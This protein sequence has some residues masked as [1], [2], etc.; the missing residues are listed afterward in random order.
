MVVQVDQMSRTAQYILVRLG[1]ALF[2]KTCFD[3]FRTSH[4]GPAFVSMAPGAGQAGAFWAD[5]GI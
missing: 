5:V 1:H 3:V 2:G 4:F